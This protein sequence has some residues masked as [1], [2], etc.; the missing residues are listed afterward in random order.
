MMSDNKRVFTIGHLGD[1]ERR[2]EWQ[3]M[4][5]PKLVTIA[6]VRDQAK[7]FEQPLCKFLLPSTLHKSF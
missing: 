7:L 6:S 4:D 3:G 2:D 1:K 5:A